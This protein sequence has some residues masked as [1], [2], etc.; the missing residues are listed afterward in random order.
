MNNPRTVRVGIIGGGFGALITYVILRFRGVP[1]TD[2]AIFSPDASPEKSWEGFARAINLKTL[3]SE[4]TGHVYPTDS[5]G[6]ATM[7]AVKTWSLRPIIQSWFDRYHPTVD[8]FLE[9]TR[10]IARQTGFYRALVPSTISHLERREDNFSIYDKNETLVA[11]AQHVMLAV[12]HG[13]ER[14]PVAV[15]SF[16]RLHPQDTRVVSSFE[17]KAYHPHSV[18]VIGDGITAATEWANV[19]EAGGAVSAVS[20]H[21]FNLHQPL[22]VPRR[23][24]SRR[25][26]APYRRKSKA[27]RLAELQAATRGTIPASPAWQRLFRQA[28]REGRLGLVKGF[29]KN[30]ERKETGCLAC[31]VEF[32]DQHITH[33]IVIDQVI[34]AAGFLP[35]STHPLLARLIEQYA[36]PAIDGVLQLTD[37]CCVEK[38]STPNSILAV[39]G[40]AAA[41]AI[42]SAD[43]FAGMKISARQFARLVAG[44]E[45]MSVREIMRQMRR[46]T[47]FVTG[48]A[49]V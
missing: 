20:L 43:S 49:L 24:F 28:Q 21:G 25:G 36:L 13:R 2:I 19:L 8:F 37:D 31:E 39:I 12:G 47:Q 4:S 16:R 14:L 34:S 41:W 3:R 7:Q 18:L 46:W 23:Y 17:S 11:V 15:T 44:P 35:P 22:Q 45:K 33:T 9:H 32:A 30:I 38:I 40:P 27:D 5:P 10:R 26:L 48:K 42:P 6:L 29:V 1:A